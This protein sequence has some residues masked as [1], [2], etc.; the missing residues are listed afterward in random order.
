MLVETLLNKIP[1]PSKKPD[2]KQAQSEHRNS[3]GKRHV[4]LD[5]GNCG[6]RNQH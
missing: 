2:T 3:F 1:E 6:T 4:W 5:E